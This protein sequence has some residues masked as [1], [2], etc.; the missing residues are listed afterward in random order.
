MR[1]GRL[2]FIS[3]MAAFNPESNATEHVGDVIAQSRYVYENMARLLEAAGGSLESVVKTVEYVAPA[4][5]ESYPRT[6]RVRTELFDRPYLASTGVI[7]ERLLR[8]D[9]LIEVDAVAVLP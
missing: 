3:G 4:G 1:A 8:S 5:R 7:C 2:L 9:L 6:G